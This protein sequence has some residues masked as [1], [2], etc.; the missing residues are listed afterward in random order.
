MTSLG[1]YTVKRLGYGPLVVC[2]QA[3]FRPG[4]HSGRAS[5]NLEYGKLKEKTQPATA[6]SQLRHVFKAVPWMWVETVRPGRHLPIMAP[7]R[8]NEVAH[9]LHDAPKPGWVPSPLLVVFGYGVVAKPATGMSMV[10]PPRSSLSFVL[11]AIWV[12]Q[13]STLHREC[14]LIT[15]PGQLAESV[16]TLP[17]GLQR[18]PGSS[19]RPLNGQ[20]LEA[21]ALGMHAHLI[22]TDAP[23]LVPAMGACTQR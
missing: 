1:F 16:Y 18:I 19:R 17:R 11:W 21:T 22:S 13:S 10:K 7:A 8:S 20:S 3:E 23:T 2:G 14:L 9:T 12:Q 4:T 5:Q 15:Q 6:G